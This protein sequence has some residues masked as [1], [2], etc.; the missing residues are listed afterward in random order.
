MLNILF[1]ADV[2]GSPGRKVVKDLLPGIRRRYEIGLVIANGENS[3]AGFDVITGGNH[4]WDRKESYDYLA[5]EPR[6]VRPANMPPETRGQGFGVYRATDGTPVGVV[7]LLGRVFMKEI[8][9]PFR[10]VDA[11]LAKIA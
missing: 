7:N 3:A 10:A 5:S 9:C 11:A 2:I 8:D 6:L 1:I 4:L